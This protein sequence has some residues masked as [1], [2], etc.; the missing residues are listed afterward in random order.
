VCFQI[1][2]DGSGAFVSDKDGQ[3]TCAP[4]PDE[5]RQGALLSFEFGSH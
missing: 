4:T 2:G 1:Y 3:E 5:V